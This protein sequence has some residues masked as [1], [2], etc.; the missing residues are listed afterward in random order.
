MCFSKDFFRKHTS[1]HA[2]L[3]ASKNSFYIQSFP[4]QDLFV[5]PKQTKQN[6]GKIKKKIKKIVHQWVKYLVKI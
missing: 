5:F 3:H 6:Q 1:T 2:Q 4:N